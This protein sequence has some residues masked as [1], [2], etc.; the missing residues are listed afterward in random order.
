MKPNIKLAKQIQEQIRKEPRQFYMGYWF[1]NGYGD[2]I[3][4]CGTT[5]CIAGW[6][7]ALSWG[8]NPRQAEARTNRLKTPERDL[9]CKKLRITQFQGTKLF[10]RESWP[11]RFKRMADHKGAIKMLD[12]LIQGKL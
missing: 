9:A 6:A 5:A 1:T 8:L 7:L 4:N 10:F 12:L 2:D 3:P 11:T